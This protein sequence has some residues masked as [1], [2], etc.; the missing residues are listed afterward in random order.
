MEGFEANSVMLR[1]RHVRENPEELDREFGR[2]VV[3][4]QVAGQVQR[5]DLDTVHQNKE[6]LGSINCAMERSTRTNSKDIALGDDS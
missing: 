1:L 2:L 6:F 5:A 4:T 3:N